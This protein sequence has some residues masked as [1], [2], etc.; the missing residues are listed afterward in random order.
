MHLTAVGSAGVALLGA[1]VVV[2]F[3][4]GQAARGP[5]RGGLGRGG[6]RPATLGKEGP[7]GLT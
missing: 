3:L 4:P 2:I 5:F 7:E 1:V 6:T